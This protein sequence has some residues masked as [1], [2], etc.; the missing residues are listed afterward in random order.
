MSFKRYCMYFQGIDFQFVS[1]KKMSETFGIRYFLF[2]AVACVRA[3]W[4]AAFDLLQRPQ[5]RRTN[6]SLTSLPSGNLESLI[7]Y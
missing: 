2:N 5:F 4:S 1:T 7:V 3:S 6:R